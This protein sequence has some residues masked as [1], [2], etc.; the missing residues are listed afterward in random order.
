MT[1]LFGLALIALFMLAYGYGLVAAF[2][3]WAMALAMI[4]LNPVPDQT[5]TMWLVV[6]GLA[7]FVIQLALGLKPEEK[8]K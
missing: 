4:F 5:L 8:K 2:A 6:A 7:V 1:V 3:M